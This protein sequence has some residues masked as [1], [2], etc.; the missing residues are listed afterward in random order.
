MFTFRA[1]NI[2]DNIIGN[3]YMKTGSIVWCLPLL[4]CACGGADDTKKEENVSQVLKAE[5]PTVDVVV[6]RRGDFSRELISNGNVVAAR[7]ADL[8]FSASERIT[9]IYVSNGDRVRKGQALARIDAYKLEADLQAKK[10]ALD[11]AYLDLQDELIGRG[12]DIRDTSAVPPAEM[13]LLRVKSGYD[14]AQ[15]SYRLAQRALRDATL[16]APF[17]GTV[18]NLFSRV[19]NL[20]S[21]GEPFCTIVGGGAMR[22]DF[23]VLEGELSLIRKGRKV[24][25]SPFA[26]LDKTFTGTITQINPVVDKTGLVKISA[27][28]PNG[29]GA[30]YDGMNV[31][32]AINDPVPDRLVVPKTAMVLRSGGRSVIFTYKNG[33]SFWNYIEA[34][35]ENSRNMVVE[36]GLNEGDTVIV[37]GNMNL[38][39]D[40]AVKIDRVIE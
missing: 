7:K 15:S 28:V 35:E 19:H 24:S 16:Y 22:V 17:D 36:D 20:P 21:A 9:D 39:H 6:L 1:V 13:E 8:Q 5:E 4:L 26:A 12:Y 38:A 29:D 33:R 23:S 32:V 14:N 11:K 25:V 18:A 2:I 27:E 31:R 10:S 37:S 3:Q 30:L 40:V 34:G